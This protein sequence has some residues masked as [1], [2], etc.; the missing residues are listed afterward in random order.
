[1]TLLLITLVLTNALIWLLFS[2]FYWITKLIGKL[3][4]SK[5]IKKLKY[6]RFGY[7]CLA[8]S[9]V[10]TLMAL[11]GFVF[12]RFKYEVT[13]LEYAHHDI[14][15]VFD[16]YR[17]VQISDMHLEGFEGHEAFVDTLVN[18]INDLRPDLVCFTGDLVSFSSDGLLPYIN[19]LQR[20]QTR[21]GVISILGN[22]DYGIY[23]RTLVTDKNNEE[24]RAKLINIQRDSL[25]W[26]LLLNENYILRRGE[27][28]IAIIGSENQ[29]CTVHPKVQRG[30]LRKAMEGTDGCFQILLTH[31]PTHWDAEVLDNTQIPLTLS[32]HTHAMQFRLLG[33]SPCNWFYKRAYGYYEENGQSIYV[34]IGLGQIMPFR[35]GATPEIT[36][37]TLRKNSE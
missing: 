15:E 35:I 16:G 31:D 22:H 7:F 24:D 36:L 33:W 28:S 10:W 26:T 6:R 30:D 17:I 32:G 21:D 1:M 4:K 8:N 5:K 2:S 14:P 11:Y 23:H 9:A 12:G 20:I 3:T 29:A 34:N 18:A 19:T 25:D 13:E 37:I 27:D